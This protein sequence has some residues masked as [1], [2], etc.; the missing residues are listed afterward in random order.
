MKRFVRIVYGASLASV[1]STHRCVEETPRTGDQH[2]APPL[3]AVTDGSRCFGRTGYRRRSAAS[4]LSYRHSDVRDA[5]RGQR[6]CRRYSNAPRYA[7]PGRNDAERAAAEPPY[8]RLIVIPTPGREREI[9]R[10]MVERAWGTR[11]PCSCQHHDTVATVTARH[12]HPGEIS[13]PRAVEEPKDWPRLLDQHPPILRKHS[14][15]AYAV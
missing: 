11:V 15:Q 10:S 4:R 9:R 2:H 8:L 12:S 3:P 7:A 5:L 13:S 6:S 14:T 1:P